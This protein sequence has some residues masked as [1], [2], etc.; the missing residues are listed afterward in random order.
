[1]SL[2]WAFGTGTAL[3]GNS[4]NPTDTSGSSASGDGESYTV[5][6]NYV[7]RGQGND[8]QPA[9]YSGSFT[10]PACWYTAMTP[11]QMREEIKRRYYAAG[12]DGAGTIYEF[13]NDQ[14]NQMEDDGH[15]HQG[16]DGNW[17]VL[18]WDEQR[19]KD[20][21]ATCPYQQG[22]FWA[23]PNQPP[24][25]RI[26]PRMLADAAYGQ[27]TLPSRG[28]TL[29]PVAQNQKVNLPTYVNFTQADGEVS[30][31]AQVTEPDGQVIA[32]TVVA[33]PTSLHV[34]AGTQYADPPS[35]DY[36]MTGAKLNS[37]GTGCNIT[38]NRA[39]HGTYP[40]TADMTWTVTWTPTADPAPGGQ[41]LQPD[42]FS[43]SRQDVTVQ[44]IQAINR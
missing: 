20:F 31:T 33:Q 19:L 18:T 17:W 9:K 38:Y 35:C 27:L 39:S 4:A 44:E 28:V 29:S 11:D 5:Q 40:F 21:S 32:A 16:Q 24:A 36:D 42:G 15:Y 10:P 41:R 22:Y 30:V 26:T 34:E 14:N 7:H 12:H 25:G 37:A 8:S 13:Y 23:P 3:A 43:E 1:M 2:V 6:V